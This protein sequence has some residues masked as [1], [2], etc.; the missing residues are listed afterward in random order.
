MIFMNLS[1]ESKNIDNHDINFDKVYNKNEEFE[2]NNRCQ[3]SKKYFLRDVIH[4]IAEYY[5]EAHLTTLTDILLRN[6]C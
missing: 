2:E 3:I 6:G 5:F 1:C 4:E